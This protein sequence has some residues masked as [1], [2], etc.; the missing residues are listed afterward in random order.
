M[1]GASGGIGA[2]GGSGV[3]GRNWVRGGG[4]RGVKDGEKQKVVG[5]G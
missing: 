5:V 1:S 3:R 2:R 4:G